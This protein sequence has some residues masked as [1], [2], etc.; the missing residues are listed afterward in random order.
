MEVHRK[1]IGS[2]SAGSLSGVYREFDRREIPV[3]CLQRYFEGAADRQICF[4]SLNFSQYWYVIATLSLRYRYVIGTLSLRCWAQI[5]LRSRVA[6]ARSTERPPLVWILKFRSHTYIYNWQP[7]L[8]WRLKSR[9]KILRRS[10]VLRA[11][12]YDLTRWTPSRP[13]F[14]NEKF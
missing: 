8:G 14:K 10:Q 7:N 4:R 5:G 1:F 11:S 13:R 9:A 3:L 2:L 6:G 12:L